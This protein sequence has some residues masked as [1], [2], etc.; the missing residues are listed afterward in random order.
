MAQHTYES[1]WAEHP[2]AAG[3]ESTLIDFVIVH[4]W[5][6]AAEAMTCT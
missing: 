4:D 2:L 1:G 5:E 6:A 3:L